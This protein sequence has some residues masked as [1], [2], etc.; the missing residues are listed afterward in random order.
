[1]RHACR[2]CGSVFM[3]ILRHGEAGN[4]LVCRHCERKGL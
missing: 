3:L 4:V 2:F 1:M